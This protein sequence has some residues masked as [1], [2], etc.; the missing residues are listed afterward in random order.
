MISV[1]RHFQKPWPDAGGEGRVV[2]NVQ[3]L[4]RQPAGF[5]V[6]AE[7]MQ[8]DQR[9]VFVIEEDF[10]TALFPVIDFRFPNVQYFIEPGFQL[11]VG[12]DLIQP[13]VPLHHVEQGVHGAGGHH[14]VFAEL[15]VAFGLPIG[16]ECFQIA[17]R[18]PAF[19]FDDAE[20]LLSPLQGIG[21]SAG[22]EISGKGI[23]GKRLVVGVLGAVGHL[24]VRA[25]GPVYAA[26]LLIRHS[27]QHSIGVMRFFQQGSVLQQQVRFRKEP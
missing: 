17:A 7:G 10:L 9:M 12:P 5:D 16:G 18:V 1:I 24:A 3:G 13:R 14:A 8:V 11:R 22:A 4:F 19:C 20:Q 15:F 2:Q 26:I 23:N 25:Q 6:V 27:F 21:V